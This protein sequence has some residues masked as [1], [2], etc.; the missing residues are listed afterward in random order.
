MK[1]ITILLSILSAY[2]ISAQL[3]TPG[4][5]VNAT[6]TPLSNNVGIGTYSPNSTLEVGNS[7]GAKLTI[8]TNGGSAMSASP[9]Y[10]M[11]EF[12][13]Y[14]NSPKARIY[15]SEES[16]NTNGS[17]FS[18]AVNDGAGSTSIIER[19]TILKNGNTGIGVATPAYT[20]DV[21]GNAQ[22][23]D[24][25]SGGSNAWIFQTPD[26]GS[27][28][29]RLA[30]GGAGGAWEW[31]KAFV[32]S[33]DTGNASLQGKFEAKEVKVTHTPTADFV[34][35]EDYN[36]PK[37]EDIEK[38]IKQKKHLPEIASAKQMEKEGVNIGE[39]QIQLLQK[40][41][42][43]TLYTIEQNK[44]LKN[45]QERIQ[46]LEKENKEI[47]NQHSEI[48]QLKKLILKEKHTAN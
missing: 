19:F 20:L 23:Q 47:K 13:G 5:A 15:S 2:F 37:L 35:E 9:L 36:L 3:Y 48:E 27:K 7:N 6:T 45:Q 42:E 1:K 32:L 4:N 46:Q 30:Y 17:K 26:D 29:L 39:F 24:I 43:L 44:Q 11:L 14:L 38:H 18:I 8:S 22:F 12:A 41:E 10:P 31:G 33:G 28:T 16:G 34:F 21:A 25:I 40:I